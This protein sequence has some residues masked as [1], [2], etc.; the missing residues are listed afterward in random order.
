MAEE[1]E[2]VQEEKKKGG[3]GLIIVLL[4]VVILLLIGVGVLVWLLLSADKGGDDAKSGTEIH[5]SAEHGS[6]D[7]VPASE[8]SHAKEYSPK[9]KQFDPPPPA[10]PPM[11]FTMD[12]LVVNFNGDGQAKF[13]A[14][15]FKFMSYYAQIVGE[16]GEM[17]HLRP[18]LK[19]DIE[20]LLRNKHYN[21]LIKPEG[22]D[23]LRAEVLD[24]TRKVLEKHN[25]YPDLLEDVYMTRFV[26]Q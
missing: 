8:L 5:G 12:K 18:M 16:T 19:N 6:G 9:Y 10:T 21:E 25:I 17:E 2:E 26:M 11:Y 3:K 7:D 14:V 4:V 13:L 23:N 1:A 15:D 24:V 22:P 20:R